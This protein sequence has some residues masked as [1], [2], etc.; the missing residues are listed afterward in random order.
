MHVLVF[1]FFLFPSALTCTGWTFSSGSGVGSML[2]MCRFGPPWVFRNCR[3]QKRFER[4]P[5]K[6]ILIHK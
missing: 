2:G 5:Y 4:M 1:P 6:K 3:Q